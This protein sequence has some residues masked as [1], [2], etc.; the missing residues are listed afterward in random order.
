M[1]WWKPSRV[2]KRA[3][4][5]VLIAFPLTCSSTCFWGRRES[6]VGQPNVTR[7]GPP[8]AKWNFEDTPDPNAAMRV[9]LLLCNASIGL[10]VVTPGMQKGEIVYLPKP[11][12]G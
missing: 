2:C 6:E 11:S 5:L 10:A 4:L 3:K 1:S 9:V 8:D 7:P 12:E